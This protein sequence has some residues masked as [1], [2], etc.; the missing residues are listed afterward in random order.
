MNHA[1]F[2]GK[3][4]WKPADRALTLSVAAQCLATLRCCSIIRDVIIMA[5][6]YEEEDFYPNTFS[7][8]LTPPVEDESLTD[9]L[10]LA[11]EA[12]RERAR[13]SRTT[14]TIDKYYFY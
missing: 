13:V 4:T 8:R 1:Y 7:F 14:I 11:Q 9:L 5:D 6:I 10:D 12:L 3:Y 2:A